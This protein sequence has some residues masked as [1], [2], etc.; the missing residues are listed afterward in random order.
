MISRSQLHFLGVTAALLAARLSFAEPPN[1][2]VSDT[3]TQA[4]ATEAPRCAK[5]LR[6]RV[7]PP[8]LKTKVRTAR[9]SVDLKALLAPLGIT[10]E[11]MRSTCT[12]APSVVLDVFQARIV[13][14]DTRDFV[15]QARGMVCGDTR[16][17][18]GVVLHPLE[19][20]DTFCAIDMP[21]L[22]GMPD[23]YQVRTTFGLETLTDPVRQVF[24]VESKTSDSRNETE[25]LEYWEA[26]DGELHL[27]FIIPTKNEHMG[28]V[29]SVS[30]AKVTVGGSGFPRELL[31]EESVRNCGRFIDLPSGERALTNDCTEAT[32]E[33][34]WCFQRAPSGG[35]GG[36]RVCP[37]SP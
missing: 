23:A 22:P 36:Y 3:S 8:E 33:A 34:R 7:K 27:L 37:P 21:F 1:P 25:S 13:S 30:S 15:L 11:W 9:S 31:I 26:Y 12:E 2:P 20:P 18:D 35:A 32:N 14:A 19:E 29:N 10:T 17:L 5:G 16:L 6:V 4:P 28:F 24:R